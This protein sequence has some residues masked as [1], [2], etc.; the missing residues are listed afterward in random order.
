MSG[1]RL[2]KRVRKRANINTSIR[3]LSYFSA[4]GPRASRPLVSKVDISHMLSKVANKS[5]RSTK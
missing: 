3:G 1:L 4:A 2:I 5:V